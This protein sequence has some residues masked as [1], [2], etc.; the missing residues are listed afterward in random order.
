[1]YKNIYHNMT[2]GDLNRHSKY[3]PERIELHNFNGSDSQSV[4]FEYE[5]ARQAMNA[6]AMIKLY[7]KRVSMPVVARQRHNFVIIAR[8]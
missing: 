8:K 4:G 3:A 5:D 7:A 2:I 6:C 1:M